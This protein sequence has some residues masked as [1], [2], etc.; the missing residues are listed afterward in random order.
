MLTNSIAKILPIYL[1]TIAKKVLIYSW[2][3]AKILLKC[4]LHVPEGKVRVAQVMF[5]VN[6]ATMYLEYCQHVHEH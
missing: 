3:V 6:I 1:W 2:T 5:C 4:F